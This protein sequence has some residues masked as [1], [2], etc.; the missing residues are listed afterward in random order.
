ME[1]IPI[2]IPDSRSVFRETRTRTFFVIDDVLDEVKL[3]DGLARLIQDH[4]RKL[5]ARI[6]KKDNNNFEYRLPNVFRPDYELFRMTTSTSPDSIAK[7]APDLDL[8]PSSPHGGPILLAGTD[9]V[10][11]H[12]R[13]QHWPMT[14]S[15][16]PDAPL[17]LIHM[18]LYS[19]ATVIATSAPH[20]LA[21]QMGLAL[22]V[23]AW[24]GV[25]KGQAPPPMV[26][27][28]EDILPGQK[29][30]T[31]Y[32]KA[33]FYKR[34]RAHL[35]RPGERVFQLLRF[36]WEMA[37]EPNED[38]VVL[39]FPAELVQTLR[40]RYAS[41]TGKANSKSELSAGD[42]ITAVTTKLARITRKSEITMSLSQ[43]INYRNR[44]PSLPASMSAGYIHNALI[45]ATA[46]IR[47]TPSIPVSTIAYANRAA[48]DK[49]ASNPELIDTLVAIQREL[50][51]RG[52]S[53][54]ICEM[55]ETSYHMTNW[56]PAWRDL[57]FSP[58]LADGRGKK[59]LRLV[60]FGEG[61]KKGSPKRYISNLMC[62]SED[63][64]WVNFGVPTRTMVGLKRYLAA[65]PL[66]ERLDDGE[67]AYALATAG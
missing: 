35:K 16:E 41:A 38:H 67:A 24:M 58:A 65:D 55:F 28:N 11:A 30:S 40:E 43:T 8:N 15:D 5:G 36:I 56:A 48:V 13:P 33:E 25:V 61:S 9:V 53:D 49:V 10:D 54:H 23:R 64:Y 29:P 1:V 42:I 66:L 27:Y 52:Q 21:D 63:G 17:L 46:R 59:K 14:M 57:D 7:A 39:F 34:G 62:K 19:D 60:V 12:F 47:Y 50:V 4:W 6:V 2:S 26:G 44:I 45:Y 22:I 32:P 37:R 3:R 18:S 31:S 51:R 20:M